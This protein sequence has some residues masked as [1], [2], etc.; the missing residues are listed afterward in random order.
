[1]TDLTYDQLYALTTRA[2][3]LRDEADLI[4]HQGITWKGRAGQLHDCGR[5]LV[6][7]AMAALETE[8]KARR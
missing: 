6:V 7:E 2:D 4:R 5:R 8:R 1:M 3:L